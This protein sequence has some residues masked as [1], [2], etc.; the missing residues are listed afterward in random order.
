MRRTTTP[1]IRAC[2]AVAALLALATACSS[3]SSDETDK[4]TKADR[5]TKTNKRGKATADET[6]EKSLA[7]IVRK[8]ATKTGRTSARVD[9]TIV[10]RSGGQE[11]TLS[12]SGPFDLARD[13]GKLSV[14]FPGGAIDHIDEVF[15]GGKVYVRPLSNLPED[16]WLVTDRAKAEAHHL[17]RAPAN[18]PE[19]VLRQISA[20]RGVTDAGSTTID[21]RPMALYTG[22]ID[23]DTLAMGLAQKVRA[24][25]DQVRDAQGDIPVTA[26]AWV[27]EDGRLARVELS[28]LVAATTV[29][30]TMNLSGFG[31]AVRVSPPDASQT[32]PGTLNGGV[33]P[34]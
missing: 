24:P 15:T 34:G 32:V 6:G 29:D 31:K 21:G 16:Q 33:L 11:Y 20:M 23:H 8:A 5:T 30:V 3:D 28:C 22:T 10:L 12:V 26:R 17:L 13:K 9:E 25:L 14:D 1:A 7:E 2:A 19:H 27:D 4:A 18:D